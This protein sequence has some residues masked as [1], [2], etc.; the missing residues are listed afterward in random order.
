[1]SKHDTKFH[2]DLISSFWVILL[3]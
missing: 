3:K 2:T 1:M